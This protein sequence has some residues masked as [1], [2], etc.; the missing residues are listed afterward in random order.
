MKERTEV[1]AKKIWVTKGARFNAHRRLTAKHHSFLAATAF[2]SVY[3]VFLQLIPIFLPADRV[4]VDEHILSLVTAFLA[5]AILVLSLLEHGR[6]YQLRAERLHKCGMELNDLYDELENRKNSGAATPDVVDG[7]SQRYHQ[8]L[9]SIPEN[10]EPIDNLLF[11]AQHR[12]DFGMNAAK[13]IWA[14]VW[15]VL[16]TRGLAALLIFGFPLLVLLW[17]MRT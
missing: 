15:Y 17:L 1:L 7:I 14:Y 4:G 6:S 13:T 10:H 9:R 8:A 2:M 11:R 12:S 16:A 5:I 3:V